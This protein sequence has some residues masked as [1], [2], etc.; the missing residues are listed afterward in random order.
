MPQEELRVVFQHL[1][2]E[3]AGLVAPA[4]PSAHPADRLMRYLVGMGDA[5]EQE[6]AAIVGP[7]RAR[8]MRKKNNGWG[9]GYGSSYGCPGESP[10]GSD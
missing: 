5:L 3:R 4:A 8:A 2:Q 9:H 10:K 7:D 6:V 1:S